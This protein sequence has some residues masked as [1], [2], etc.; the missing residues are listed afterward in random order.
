VGVS[1]CLA[2]HHCPFLNSGF[3]LSSRGL[4]GAHVPTRG[5]APRVQSTRSQPDVL[6][7]RYNSCSAVARC[8]VGTSRPNPRVR[9]RI[10]NV[11]KARRSFFGEFGADL[12]VESLTSGLQGARRHRP[13]FYTMLRLSALGGQPATNPRL[14][15][16]A[17]KRRG[18][19]GLRR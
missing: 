9:P 1:I 18:A 17:G 11:L 6:S 8:Q 4:A 13:A 15:L 7:D 16:A 3:S 14:R 19:A 12:L 2:I 10:V 5:F